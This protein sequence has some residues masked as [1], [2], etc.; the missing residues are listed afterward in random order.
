MDRFAM[1]AEEVSDVGNAAVFEF[2]RFVGRVKATLAFVEGGVS[3]PH[4]L[5]DGGGVGVEQDGFL[6]RECETGPPNLPPKARAKKIKWD[7]Y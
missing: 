3:E 7:S 1:A 5:F 4:H 2:E 6:P